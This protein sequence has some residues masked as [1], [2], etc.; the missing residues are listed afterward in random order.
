MNN[1]RGSLEEKERKKRDRLRQFGDVL[2]RIDSDK[3]I[4]V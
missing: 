1:K 2:K 4:R 3:T